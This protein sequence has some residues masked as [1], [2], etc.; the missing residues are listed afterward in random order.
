MKTLNRNQKTTV[1]SFFNVFDWGRKGLS[2]LATIVLL[3]FCL[4]AQNN[5]DA[6][7]GIY[8]KANGNVKVYILTSEG[9][10]ETSS[11]AYLEMN[12]LEESDQELK[13]EKWMVEKE[14]F[15]VTPK[16][17]VEVEKDEML[18]LQEWMTDENYFTQKETEQVL[19][20]E[21]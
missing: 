19:Y 18:E 15:K 11:R 21:K 3:S 2:V 1:A 17:V 16:L 9:N 7:E 12:I 4:E 6:L 5:S 10:M 14:Y 8:E 13:L 20:C